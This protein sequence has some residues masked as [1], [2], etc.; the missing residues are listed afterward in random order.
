MVILKTS[1]RGSCESEYASPHTL[2]ISTKIPTEPSQRTGLLKLDLTAGGRARE[3]QAL[4]SYLGKRKKPKP[5][6]ACEEEAGYLAATRLGVSCL[7]A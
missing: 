3:R 6:C 4:V 7:S 5:H 1:I 2:K